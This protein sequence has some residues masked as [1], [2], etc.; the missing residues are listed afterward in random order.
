[1]KLNLDKST[2]DL[3]VNLAFCAVVA[4]CCVVAYDRFFA[5][6]VPKIYVIDV[7]KIET[8][9][10]RE[11]IA[12]AYNE[13]NGIPI[14]KEFVVKEVEK[15]ALFIEKVGKENNALIFRKDN[16]LADG[17]NVKDITEQVLKM[18]AKN[19]KDNK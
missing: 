7:A 13:N 1:M 12:L 19:L 5:P 8:E 18:Y 2:K 15:L 9:I 10:R 11:L 6:S 3:L 16:L 14:D 4:V 17:K